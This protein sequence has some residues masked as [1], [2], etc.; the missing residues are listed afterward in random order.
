MLK[1]VFIS[2]GVIYFFIIISFIYGFRKIKAF[3]KRKTDS[4]Q[5]KHKLSVIATFKNEEEHLKTLIE[6]LENQ[7]L[8]SS[9]YELILVNDHSSD[10]SFEIAQMCIS[11]KTQFKLISLDETLTGKKQALTEGISAAEGEVIITTDADCEHPSNWLETIFNYYSEYTPK[12]IIAP[13]AMNG[14]TVFEKMQALE[15]LSLA[16]STAGAAG[17]QM[18][19]MCNGANLAFEKAVFEELNDGLQM[20][21]VSGDDVFLLH[22]IKK[23]YPKGIHYLKSTDAIVTTYAEKNLKPFFRQRIRWASKAGS[24]KDT[25]TIFISVLVFFVNLNLIGLIPAGIFIDEMLYS[26]LILFSLKTIPDFLLISIFG[27]FTKQN[28]LL[29]FFPLLSILYPFY[30]VISATAG[31]FSRRVVWK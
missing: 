26:L 16:G 12:M 10:S 25:A 20:K 23:K 13:V 24:Y 14:K 11:D 2:A 27:R 7:S 3:N 4:K 22:S 6:N 9:L 19:V 15:F 29:F 5:Y 21:E 18:P 8:N 1:I 31:L 28:K 17:L 30:I